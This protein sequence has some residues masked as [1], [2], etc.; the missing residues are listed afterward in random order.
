MIILILLLIFILGFVLYTYNQPSIDGSSIQTLVGMSGLTQPQ[1]TELEKTFSAPTSFPQA[2]VELANL[3]VPQE[4]IMKNKDIIE[5][6][7]KF[8]QEQNAISLEIKKNNPES[9]PPRFGLSQSA[10]YTS[11]QFYAQNTGLILPKPVGVG[12]P[13]Q[14]GGTPVVVDRTKIIIPGINYT[15]KTNL[16]VYNQN[17]CGCCWAV[18]VCSLLNYQ[19]FNPS[20][21][22]PERIAYP[23]VF[24]YCIQTSQGCRGGDPTD[25]INLTNNLQSVYTIGNTKD[26]LYF[27]QTNRCDLNQGSFQGGNILDTPTQQSKA[28]SGVIA[29]NSTGSFSFYDKSSPAQSQIFKQNLSIMNPTQIEAIKYVL[30][31]NGPLVVC[32]NAEGRQFQMYK[33]GLFTP[34]LP[35]GNPD[36][37]VLLTGY[38]KDKQSGREYW[39]IQNS[40][41]NIWGEGGIIRTPMD[42]SYLG[43]LVGI[44]SPN[45][46]IIGAIRR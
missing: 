1:L 37:A 11:E 17:S 30:S 40:W 44:V 45:S 13:L 29:M 9:D 20:K 8:I 32:I 33:G 22:I 46:P 36:H 10:A 26:N 35:G 18:S 12:S 7:L 27:K 41:D 14:G 28:F 39:I 25:A 24:V 5:D 19:L 16:P 31:V 34:G 15:T 2:A 42:N 21:P 38:D 3:G 4:T 6:N 43:L 23:N